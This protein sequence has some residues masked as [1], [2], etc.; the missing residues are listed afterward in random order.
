MADKFDVIV[1]GA[2]PGGYVAAIHAAG[3]RALGLGGECCGTV[4]RTGKDVHHVKAGDVV[5]AVPPAGMGSF[6]VTD[7]RWVSPPLPW[8]VTKID[9]DREETHNTKSL[10]TSIT[11]TL[12]VL[13]S[14]LLPP[15]VPLE[16]VEVVVAVV[17][18]ASAAAARRRHMLS[19]RV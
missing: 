5:V 3:G 8:E 18:A 15:L 6:L 7:R 4:T 11:G 14:P 2:G 12:P 17:E 16:G 1:I 19:G 13:P 10:S 9:G